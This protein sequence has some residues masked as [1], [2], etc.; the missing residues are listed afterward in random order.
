MPCRAPACTPQS[1][2][3]KCMH[4]ATASGCVMCFR[5]AHLRREK[6][7][8]QMGRLVSRARVQ[9]RRA[10][11]RSWRRRRKRQGRARAKRQPLLPQPR[12]QQPGE[13]LGPQSQPRKP[14]MMTSRC[15]ASHCVCY[16]PRTSRHSLCVPLESI[17]TANLLLHVTR[18]EPIHW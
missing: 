12:K 9:A 4:D 10:I 5:Q 8:S 18:Q 13:A 15:A 2:Q 17:C 16:C 11:R 3:I 6:R 7:K 1:P 14:E